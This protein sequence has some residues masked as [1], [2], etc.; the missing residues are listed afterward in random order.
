MR[1]MQHDT[2]LGTAVPG[3]APAIPVI[4]V[5]DGGPAEHARQRIEQAQ[6]LREACLGLFPAAFNRALPI[7][8]RLARRSLERSRSPYV[9]EIARIAEILESPGVW[10]LNASYQLACTSLARDEAGV[11]GLGRTLDWPFHCLG[12]HFQVPH[13]AGPA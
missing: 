8:N 5:R 2:D 12:G 7:I 11:P 9:A 3:R 10:L 1:S 13:L 6:A 4:D